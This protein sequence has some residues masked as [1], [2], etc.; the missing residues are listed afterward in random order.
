[1]QNEFDYGQ[2]H[3]DEVIGKP[4]ASNGDE[5]AEAKTGNAG[6]VQSIAQEA[7]ANYVLARDIQLD[8]AL[9]ERRAFSDEDL[10]QARAVVRTSTSL[11]PSRS[12]SAGTN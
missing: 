7:G 6:C 3:A 8:P 2:S 5:L 4:V 9:H 12:W 1:M 10:A 11:R